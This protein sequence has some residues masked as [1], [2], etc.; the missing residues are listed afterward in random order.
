MKK[1]YIVIL[2]LLLLSTFCSSQDIYTT[3]KMARIEHIG[4]S[5]KPIY[6]VVFCLEKYKPIAY[7]RIVVLDSKTFGAV[8][9][10]IEK[11]QTGKLRPQ[12]YELGVF[13]IV[14]RDYGGLDKFYVLPTRTFS[15]DYFKKLEN[16][17]QH[18]DFHE[19][20]K[21]LLMRIRID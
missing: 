9:D 13:K 1:Y 2:L 14:V 6:T 7:E 21:E 12:T 11:N 8:C 10:Y 4:E 20:I 19:A 17:V 16:E 5:D 3:I 15:I 18:A